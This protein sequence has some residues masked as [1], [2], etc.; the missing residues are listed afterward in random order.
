MPMH[1]VAAFYTISM[2]NDFGNLISRV[3]TICSIMYTALCNS[4]SKESNAIKLLRTNG[5]EL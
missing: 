3:C 4:K 5:I 2:T 1:E